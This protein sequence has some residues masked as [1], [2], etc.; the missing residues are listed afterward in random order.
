[1]LKNGEISVQIWKNMEKYL[2]RYAQICTKICPDME[3]SAAPYGNNILL[4]QIAGG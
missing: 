4:R 3:K 2:F 1:M